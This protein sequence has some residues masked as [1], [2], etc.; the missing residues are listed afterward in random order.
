MGCWG[1][2]TYLRFLNAKASPIANYLVHGID[3]RNHITS[4]VYPHLAVSFDWLRPCSVCYGHYGIISIF[5]E[6]FSW[7]I[8][9]EIGQCSGRVRYYGVV[10]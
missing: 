8:C 6:Y 2:E 1:I 3:V 7:D 9:E 5:M 10:I 4:V